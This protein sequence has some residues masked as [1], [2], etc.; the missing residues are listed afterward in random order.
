[1]V[2][3]GLSFRMGQ[4][5][6]VQRDHSHWELARKPSNTPSIYFNNEHWRKL[7]WGSFL[8]DKYVHTGQTFR[9]HVWY[10]TLLSRI[11]SLFMGRPTFMHD[12]DAD[13]DVSEPPPL[14]LPNYLFA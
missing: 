10:L 8:V 5:L 7:Y 1:M 4:E 14:V 9:S 11:L 12:T 13:V 2:T 3:T 6:G